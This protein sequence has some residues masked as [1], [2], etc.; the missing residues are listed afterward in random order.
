MAL[1]EV[2][3]VRI[4]AGARSPRRLALGLALTLALTGLFAGCGPP[5]SHSGPPVPQP[6]TAAQ[7]CRAQ[8]VNNGFNAGDAVRPI[9][10]KKPA[11][12]R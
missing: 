3:T 12:R 9:P 10:T 11:E 1:Q 7:L 6:T 2:G 5:L 4:I 8:G